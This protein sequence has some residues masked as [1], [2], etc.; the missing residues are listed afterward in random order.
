MKLVQN[1]F[2]IL[3]PCCLAL[4][5]QKIQVP[6]IKDGLARV[7]PEFEDPGKW[8]RQD[9]WVETCFDSDGDG[10][11][12]RMHVDVTRPGQTEEGIRLPVVYISSPYFAGTGP[13]DDT[14]MWD[15]RHELHTTPP[16]RR[17]IRPIE[18]ENHRPVISN[19]HVEEW[20]PYGFIVV[21]SSAPGTGLSEGCP[22]VGGAN[23]ALAPKAVIDW[24]NGRA[25]GYTTPDGDQKV[26]AYWTTGKVG[27]TG[28]SYNGTIP[29]A[30]A[31]TGVEGLEAIIPVAPN[32]SYYHYYRSN[33]LVRHPGGWLGEDIDYLYDWIFS[34]NRAKY[35]YCNYHIRDL[36][37]LA[38]H[39]RVSGD[40]NDFWA[41]RDYLNKLG[42]LKAAVFM[43]HAFNDWNVVPEHSYRIIR[44]LKKKGV[45]LKIYYHQGGHGGEP[46]FE[47]MNRWF[48]RFLFG[49]ENG[50][51]E[52]PVARI[53][54]EGDNRLDPTPY[55]DYPN[56]DAEPV[57]LRMTPGATWSGGL[58]PAAREDISVPAA[59]GE[60]IQVPGA[61]SPGESGI[62][63]GEILPVTETL[64]DNFSFS[65]EMLARAEWTGHRLMYL[66]PVLKDSLH[67]SG[68]PSISIRLSSSK[69]SVNLSVWLVSLPWNDKKNAA[70]TDNIITRGWADP[71]NHRSLT[72]G[73]PLVPGRFY[74]MTFDLQPDD[75]V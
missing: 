14:Y 74:E 42:P 36:E 20:V 55:A 46:P 30:A 56:P 72:E 22:T 34:G 21:H 52:G 8:I 62:P 15:V 45:P 31:T 66:T 50:A 39:D 57:T 40:Y 68:P 18:A 11:M 27:M 12:D 58:V 25:D 13:V 65:G 64:V 43:A 7:V 73:E 41:G 2:L 35:D 59:R 75:Q 38:R 71:Q 23:E 37:M 6:V 69:P 17:H 53:V 32:T 24:L 44:E 51:E 70:I 63:S 28:T 67:I 29:L 19:S 26:T 5:A 4:S 60:D 16:V 49:V 10:K 9:L 61:P 54:R 47:M 33:G 1:L 3:F 48:T